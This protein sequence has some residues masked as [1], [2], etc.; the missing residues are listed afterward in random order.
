MYM[1]GC[2]GTDSALQS[3]EASTASRA[4]GTDIHCM[5]AHLPPER[6]RGSRVSRTPIG[7]RERVTKFDIRLGMPCRHPLHSPSA[8]RSWL[9]S[10]VTLPRPGGELPN[11]AFWHD[12]FRQPQQVAQKQLGQRRHG[13]KGPTVL[14]VD[15]GLWRIEVVEPVKFRDVLLV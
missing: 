1:A 5:I 9:R 10:V 4:V 2:G 12:S 14:T 6:P 15:I 3:R 7:S 11:L 8:V 13:R